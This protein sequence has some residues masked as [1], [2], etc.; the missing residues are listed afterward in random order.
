MGGAVAGALLLI[1]GR[2]DDHL[3]EISLTMIAAY[4][5][6]LLADHF[7]MSGVLAT[8]T[9]GILVGNLGWRGPISEGGRGH[10]HSFWEYAAFLANSIIFL[11]IGGEVIGQPLS[12]FLV[13]SGVAIILVLLG[14]ALAVYPLCAIF[15]WSRLRVE[16]EHQHVL[17]WGGLRGALALALAL[18]LPEQIAERR[19]IAIVAFAVVVFS[20]FVQGLTMPLLLKRVALAER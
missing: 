4:A 11:L 8:L 5:S 10:V 9:A 20:I 15:G 3:V 17:F 16:P 19:E 6:F 7:E 1:A 12:G 13:A 2:T 18:A 14:R